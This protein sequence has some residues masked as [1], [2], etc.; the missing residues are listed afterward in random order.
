MSELEAYWDPLREGSH[1]FDTGGSAKRQRGLIRSILIGFNRS[2]LIGFNRK[3]GRFVENLPRFCPCE[4]VIQPRQTYQFCHCEEGACARRGNLKRNDL[5][6]R[7]E[8]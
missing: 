4:A 3:R 8:A 5:P 7:N 6:F 1:A 2:I